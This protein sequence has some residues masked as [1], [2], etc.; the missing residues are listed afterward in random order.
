MPLPDLRTVLD[1]IRQLKAARPNATKADIEYSLTTDLAIEKERS[2]FRLRDA[3]IRISQAQ[4]ASFSN[5]VLSLSALRKYDD[6]PFVIVIIRPDAVEF[7]LANSSLLK[8]ISHSSHQLRIDNI[9]GSFLG[10]DILRKLDTLEN[11]PSNFEA[12]F[13][14][15][16]QLTWDENITRL[17]EATTAIVPTGHRFIPTAAETDTILSAPDRASLWASSHAYSDVEGALI[18]T[19]RNR[20][21]DVLSAASID[22]VNVRGNAIEQVITAAGNFH[23]LDDITYELPGLGKLHVDVKTKLLNR[24]SNPKLYNIDKTLA[25]LSKP[26][27]SLALFLVGIDVDRAL[28]AGRLISV[29][30]RCI[31]PATRIQFHWAGRASR[32]VTQLSGDVTSCFSERFVPT[33]DIAAGQALLRRFLDL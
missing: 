26:E 31:V 21:R 18:D 10:H 29:F 17:V 15:H 19:I 25:I 13:D 16:R 6:K 24:S 12:L 5:V 4:S 14:L 32:G 23:S 28:V 30:D 33:V 11:T 3:A 20:R 8:K 1:F 27:A 2:V 22:N 9:K 7:L